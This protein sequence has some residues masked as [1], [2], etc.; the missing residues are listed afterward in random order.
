MRAFAVA[1][2]VL[3]RDGHDHEDTGE[4]HP[5]GHAVKVTSVM[6]C[7]V[8]HVSPC[9]PQCLFETSCSFACPSLGKVNV[10]GRGPSLG[11][12]IRHAAWSSHGRLQV[13]KQ[14]ACLRDLFGECL[15]HPRQTGV[16]LRTKPHVRRADEHHHGRWEMLANVANQTSHVLGVPSGL[17]GLGHAGNR[18]PAK[19]KQNHGRGAWPPTNPIRRLQADSTSFQ[20]P[21]AWAGCGP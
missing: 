15:N 5:N 10:V 18:I 16:V 9:E 17:F 4:G 7:G 12:P 21:P 13:P 11:M 1:H 2:Q 19:L 14:P 8:A 3:P 6:A 20:T